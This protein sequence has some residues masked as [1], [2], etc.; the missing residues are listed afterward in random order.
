MS[1]LNGKSVL[2]TGALGGIGSAICL[3]Y[4]QQGAA[5]IAHDRV[6]PTDEAIASLRDRLLSVG[7]R[8]V[9]YQQADL[10]SR[11]EIH[12][13][14]SRLREEGRDVDI[15]V[16]NAAIQKTSPIADFPD[17]LWESIVAINLV[18][19]YHC[20]KQALV[21]MRRKGWGRIINIASVH[22][23]VASVDK[24]AYVAAKHGVVG[25][26]REVALETA[27]QGIAVNA[28][29]PGWTDTPIIAPQIEA[30]QQ[31]IGG[32]R[33]DAIRHLVSEKQPDGGLIP[34]AHVAELALYLGGESAR[35]IT[36][37]AMPID[38]GWTCV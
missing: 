7:A 13:M 37:T 33:E 21:D 22:G 14:F 30:R 34:P 12:A 16:N 35:H 36:G 17:D 2:V 3:A 24:S 23:L 11:Q 29:C 1:H 28:I 10:G 4:A 9:S 38:G 15:L 26:T 19:V 8:E 32:S 31:Q 18:A 20:T 27:G 6:E 5:V 25:F